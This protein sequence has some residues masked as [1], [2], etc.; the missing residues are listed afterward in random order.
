M[1]SSNVLHA[2]ALRSGVEY[3]AA[4]L[5]RRKKYL[6]KAGI[7]KWA[8]MDEDSAD[9]GALRLMIA[10]WDALGV[11][12]LAMPA[13]EQIEFFKANPVEYM[14]HLLKDAIEAIRKVVGAPYAKNF[15]N[16][17]QAY[18][19][20]LVDQPQEYQ[21]AAANGLTAQFA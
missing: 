7:K 2:V 5:L 12:V 14:W 21:T 10:T 11:Q 9:Y 15:E 18:H 19:A 1:P 20:W 4:E 6:G 3:R 8:K 17:A 16:L 13:S